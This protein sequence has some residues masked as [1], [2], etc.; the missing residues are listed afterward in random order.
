MSNYD[1]LD[2]L[3]ARVDAEALASECHG[4]V[5][6]QICVTGQANDILWKDFL[7][8]QSEDDDLVNACY[9]EVGRTA[10]ATMEQLHSA[11]FGLEL[12]LPDDDSSM[13]LRAEALV[14]WCH[15]FL[16]G[17]G[18]SDTVSEAGIS[19]ECE[20]VLED[21]TQICRLGIEEEEA[22]DEQSMMELIEYARMGALLIFEETQVALGRSEVLH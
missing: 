22:A 15:G 11:E 14:N 16:N 10:E 7:D 8:I 9:E 13:P 4:F 12:L 17:F 18:L 2:G 21:F 3:L 19:A 5:C 20:E 6:A 1:V